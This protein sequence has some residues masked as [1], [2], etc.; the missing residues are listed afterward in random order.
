MNKAPL[1]TD[2]QVTGALHLVI[3]WSTGETLDCDLAT[4]T[5]RNA[6]LGVCRTYSNQFGS[7]SVV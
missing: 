3:S 5:S 4:T 1:I 2:V 7:P 6:A